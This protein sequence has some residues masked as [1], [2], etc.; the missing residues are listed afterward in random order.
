MDDVKGT[1]EADRGRPNAIPT[2]RVITWL[3]SSSWLRQQQRKA[4]MTP[5][6][7][8]SPKPKSPRQRLPTTITIIHIITL[9][10]HEEAATSLMLLVLLT[11]HPEI[12]VVFFKS[13]LSDTSMHGTW[14]GRKFG[15]WMGVSRANAYQFVL[16]ILPVNS[17]VN[18][19]T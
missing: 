4:R 11:F 16:C 1:N 5:R 17:G 10:T 13:P 2:K 8:A 18:Y 15:A 3:S 6:R 14:P 7:T 12:F 19:L 9:M